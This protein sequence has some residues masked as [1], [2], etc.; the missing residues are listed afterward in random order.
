MSRAAESFV[1]GCAQQG[2]L[3]FHFHAEIVD[4]LAFR[5]S[6]CFEGFLDA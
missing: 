5:A 6:K 4:P 3:S 1:D 2:I